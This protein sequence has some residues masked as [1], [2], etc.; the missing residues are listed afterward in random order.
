MLSKEE[1]ERRRQEFFALSDKR[2]D[3]IERICQAANGG[4][5]ELALK[6]SDEMRALDPRMCEH[7]RSWSS[8]CIVCGEIHKECFP[9]NYVACGKCKNLFDPDELY[10][11]GKC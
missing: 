1:I 11:E 6:L 2:R 3:Y 7:E 5:R 8:T 4:N 10:E 9:E